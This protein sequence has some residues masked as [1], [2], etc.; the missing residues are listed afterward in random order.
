MSAVSRFGDLKCPQA[1]EEKF[2]V[3]F[4]LWAKN[5]YAVGTKAE[6]EVDKFEYT[7]MVS[8]NYSWRLLLTPK[9]RVID[10]ASNQLLTLIHDRDFSRG[11][12]RTLKNLW[13][14]RR[15]IFDDLFKGQL[16][17]A[18]FHRS[19]P[20]NSFNPASIS[21]SKSISSRRMS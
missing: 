2:G 8:E 10:I 6:W 14:P 18:V 11:L 20:S 13:V 21:F 5:F 9:R 7:G 4:D 3:S 16:F 15:A 19:I 17:P 12:I 1:M